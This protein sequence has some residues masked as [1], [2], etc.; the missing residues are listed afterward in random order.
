MDRRTSSGRRAG[1]CAG[2]LW[3][4]T[5]VARDTLWRGAMG[6]APVAAGAA[7][8]SACSRD[9]GADPGALPKG[10]WGLVDSSG[11][12]ALGPRFG[13]LSSPRGGLCLASRTFVGRPVGLEAYGVAEAASGAWVVPPRWQDVR[14]AGLAGDAFAARD[15][16]SGLWGVAGWD[17]GWLAEPFLPDGPNEGDGLPIRPFDT[18][19]G[20][21]GAHDAATGLWGL[22]DA[23]GAWVVG[24][25]FAHASTGG[26]SGLAAAHDAGSGLWG[27]VDASGSWVAPP[28]FSQ[29][30]PPG[31]SGLAAAQDPSTG[32]W[33][34]AGPSGGWAMAPSFHLVEASPASGLVAVQRDGDS[35]WGGW[36][37]VRPDGSWAVEPR[38]TDARG[39]DAEGTRGVASEGGGY[40]LVDPSG[41]WVSEARLFSVRPCGDG[42]LAAARTDPELP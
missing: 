11:G 33:G 24:P 1:F 16:R 22:I 23:S 3:G 35:R 13:D 14:T 40:G 31:S 26:S 37:F 39:F 21:A 15:A 18:A 41:E 9:E 32:A 36:G 5:G 25:R 4:V 30:E 6:G 19:S 8:L 7:G 38:F 2:D 29:L 20:L 10:Y 12:W 34:Y 17:G 28:A 27:L 42:G